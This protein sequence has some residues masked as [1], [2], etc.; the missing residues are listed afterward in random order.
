MASVD[1]RMA[2]NQALTY[3][4]KGKSKSVAPSLRLI[5]EDTN[6]EYVPP[7]T[8]THPLLHALDRIESG[9]FVGTPV[10]HVW[11]CDRLLQATK[12]LDIGL[13]RDEANVAAP[14]R[15]PHVAVPP[16][17]DD[18]VANVEQMHV[19][20]PAPPATTTD[21]QAPPSPAASQASNS[22]KATHS[23][24]S[25]LVPLES[26]PEAVPTNG[27]DTI[28]ISSLFGNEVPPS[29]SSRDTGKRPRSDRASDDD[30]AHKI[31]KKER[32]Q[33][34]VAQWASIVDKEHRQQ[35]AQDVGIGPS[36]GVSTTDGALRVDDSTIEGGEMVDR[37][38]TNGVQ[39]V[40]QSFVA[41]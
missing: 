36:S 17:R 28:V 30:E 14:H 32:Q 15:E 35:R 40:N 41:L 8:R 3:A 10:Y 26:T 9:S 37:S 1:P 25:L 22:S 24:D 11:H 34:E 18:L 16:L 12:T 13:I 38:A 23:F 19:D 5:D 2:L 20:D 39:S 33:T 29:D 31:R 4:T 7:P 6:V 27:V 21:A